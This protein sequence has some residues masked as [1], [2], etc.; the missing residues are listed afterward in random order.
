MLTGEE[1]VVAGLS[2][3]EVDEEASIVSSSSS[4]SSLGTAWLVLEWL[5][6]VIVEAADRLEH[7]L[8]SSANF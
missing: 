5:P 6:L 2:G 8:E 3:G 4:S 7:F 1:E